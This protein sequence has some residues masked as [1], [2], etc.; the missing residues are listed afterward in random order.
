M[1]NHLV[2][3]THNPLI[4]QLDGILREKGMTLEEV[5]KKSGVTV[6]C[7]KDWG[8]RT[9][10]NLRNFVAVAEVLGYDIKMEPRNEG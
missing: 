7:I 5:S 10:P 9:T 2:L 6:H 3:K 4:V 1:R 8:Y